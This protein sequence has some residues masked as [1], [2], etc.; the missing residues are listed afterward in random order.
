MD[1]LIDLFNMVTALMA[2]C[3]VIAA[4]TPT[5][6]DHTLLGKGYKILDIVAFNIGKAKEKS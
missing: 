4:F 5:P 2:S 3:S 6:K 1:Q